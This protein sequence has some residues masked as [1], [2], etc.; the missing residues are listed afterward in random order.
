MKVYAQ[1]IIDARHLTGRT[2]IRKGV[3]YREAVLPSGEK[4]MVTAETIAARVEPY[5]CYKKVGAVSDSVRFQSEDFDEANGWFKSKH[6]LILL[7]HSSAYQSSI[8]LPAGSLVK[9]KSSGH[10][11]E[12]GSIW[13]IRP[14][15]A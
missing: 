8:P 15:A 10:T 7:A 1:E 13:V 4:V 5:S 12:A 11:Y 2:G 6:D 3:P 14:T 9:A